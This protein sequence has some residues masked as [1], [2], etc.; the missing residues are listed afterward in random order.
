MSGPDLPPELQQ[1]GSYALAGSADVSSDGWSFPCLKC[2]T[3]DDRPNK[4]SCP[5]FVSNPTRAIDPDKRLVTNARRQ[6]T[7]GV[8]KPSVSSTTAVPAS[9]PGTLT[10]RRQQIARPSSSA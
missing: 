2:L 9:S 1:S 3:E 4:C 8:T 6:Q 10:S 7:F 5:C